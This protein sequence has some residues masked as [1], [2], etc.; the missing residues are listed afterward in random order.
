MW[1]TQNTESVD[2]K[3]CH[4]F[5][6]INH[7]V[8]YRRSGCVYKLKIQ[9]TSWQILLYAQIQPVIYIYIYISWLII[10]EGD[11]NV[12]F[13]IATTSRCRGGHY[14]FLWIAPLPLGPCRII[15]NV[16][17]RGIK[18]YFLSLRYDSTWDWTKLSRNIGE[19]STHF[20]NK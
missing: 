4:A 16:N 9:N 20:I 13:S 17:Q 5:P 6:A 7:V 18:N 14:S 1:P 2:I 19:H 10:V 3:V 11:P 12:L 15:L 8:C